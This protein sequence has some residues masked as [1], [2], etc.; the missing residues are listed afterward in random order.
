[1]ACLPVLLVRPLVE[2]DGSMPPG[3][4][5][6]PWCCAIVGRGPAGEAA[7]GQVAPYKGGAGAAWARPGGV[8]ASAGHR[9]VAGRREREFVTPVRLSVL[10]QRLRRGWRAD[11]HVRTRPCPGL[12]G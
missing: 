7:A 2:D 6:L 4:C 1:M 8:A 10:L 11:R 5:A 9:V 12:H 3:R